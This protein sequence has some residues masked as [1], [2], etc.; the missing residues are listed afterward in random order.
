M[1][2]GGHDGAGLLAQWVTVLAGKAN[3]LSSTLGTH[4][5]QGKL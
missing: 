2:Y 5:V 4:T 1:K 3:D